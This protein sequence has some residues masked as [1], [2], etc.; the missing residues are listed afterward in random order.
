LRAISCVAARC[1]ST[2][3]AI[4]DDVSAIEPIL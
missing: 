1:S 2:A 4:V 3:A